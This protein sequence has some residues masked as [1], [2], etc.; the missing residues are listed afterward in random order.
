MSKSQVS[1]GS[2]LQQE[3]RELRFR[4]WENW[5]DR[6]D[7]GWGRERS[8]DRGRVNHCHD[9]MFGHAIAGG[10]GC[11]VGVGGRRGTVT[12]VACVGVSAVVELALVAPAVMACGRGCAEADGAETEDGLKKETRV[13]MVKGLRFPVMIA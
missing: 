10:K 4:C 9:G 6:H 12:A 3:G 5:H 8:R 1:D 13:I 7:R 2:L 11:G